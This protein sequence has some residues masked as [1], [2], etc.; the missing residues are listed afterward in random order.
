VFGAKFNTPDPK[1]V[2]SGRVQNFGTPNDDSW[3]ALYDN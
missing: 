2:R 3:N 1:R